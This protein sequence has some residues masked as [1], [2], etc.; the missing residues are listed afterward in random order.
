MKK[1]KEIT[2]KDLA[3]LI[4]TLAVSTAKGFANMATSVND[5]WTDLKSFK[6]DNKKEHE[7]MYEAIDDL[8]D[9][10]MSYDKRIEKLETLP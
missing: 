9:T 1:K 10:V 5:M 2:N 7:E 3:K 4:D 6:Q 8:S